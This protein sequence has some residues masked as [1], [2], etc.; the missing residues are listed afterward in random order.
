M[1]LIE[2]LE[3]IGNAIRA[4]TG[5]TD[6]LSLDQMPVEIAGIEGGGGVNPADLSVFDP[7]KE[8]II[9]RS[10]A[11]QNNIFVTKTMISFVNG[12]KYAV[13]VGCKFNAVVGKTY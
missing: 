11:T 2:K 5:K 8:T 12:G 7:T 9:V 13:Y 3:A 1:A 4:K 6:K 10:T